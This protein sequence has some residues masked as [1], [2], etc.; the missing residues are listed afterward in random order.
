MSRDLPVLLESIR[1][2]TLTGITLTVYCIYIVYT[3]FKEI[4]NTDL[5]GQE[6]GKGCSNIFFPVLLAIESGLVLV[7]LS[8]VWSVI[9]PLIR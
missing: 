5:D 7:G 9:W 2:Q 6:R 8:S 4:F 1:S 3:L